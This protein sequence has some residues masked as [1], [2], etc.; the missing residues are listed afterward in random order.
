MECE[1]GIIQ[2]MVEGCCPYAFAR[3]II[4][5]N[6]QNRAFHVPVMTNCCAAFKDEGAPSSDNHI[7]W[8]PLLQKMVVECHGDKPDETAF[9]NYSL[10]VISIQGICIKKKQMQLQSKLGLKVQTSGVH[11]KALQSK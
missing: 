5:R 1:V 3:E 7:L 9:Q 11:Q 10:L 2:L 6:D 8:Q 4:G